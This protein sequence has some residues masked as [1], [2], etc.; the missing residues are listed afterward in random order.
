MTAPFG[1]KPPPKVTL[2]GIR[3]SAGHIVSGDDTFLIPQEAVVRI[4]RV[5]VE[6]CD[7]STL[8]DCEA[9]RTLAGARARARR[10]ERGKATILIAQ[11]SVAHA[12]RINV[13]P[14]DLT[15]IVKYFR[16]K[17][18]GTLAGT[19][20]RARGIETVITPCFDRT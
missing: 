3:S 18:Y 12:A 8:V 7:R 2:A 20:A 19:S 5:N 13:M 1:A 4:G 10:I 14:C 9:K 15:L 16:T 11:K 6:S 17:N